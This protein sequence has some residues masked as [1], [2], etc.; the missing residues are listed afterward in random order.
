MPSKAFGEIVEQSC[1][2]PHITPQ[3]LKARLDAGESIV[4]LDARPLEEYRRMNIPGGIDTPGAELVYR[5]R[6]LVPDANTP[7]VVNC[8]GRTRSIIGTQSLINAGIP[9][10][11]AALKGGTCASGGRAC[12][13]HAH[14]R[15]AVGGVAG[16]GR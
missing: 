5:V 15:E 1:H 3:A 10:P 16:R 13:R 4:I 11:V 7:I 12:G 8:A 6:D 9:N 14:R 2:T